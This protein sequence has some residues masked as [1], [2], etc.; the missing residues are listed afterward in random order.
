MSSMFQNASIGNALAFNQDIGD[1]DV[2]K[3]TN[4]SDMFHRVTLSIANYDALLAGWSKLTL[5]SG[6]PF[7]AG[8]SKYCNQLA[9]NVLTDSPNNWRI[10]DSNRATNCPLA[11]E[12]VIPDQSYNVNTIVSEI[13]PPAFG[14]TS[15]RSYALTGDIPPRLA[16]INPTSTVRTLAGTP[17]MTAA[18][19]TL[20]YTVTDSATPSATATLTFTVT[21]NKGEQTG[22]SFANTEV[23]KIIGDDPRS[24]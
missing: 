20:T 3:V 23:I 9:K 1:W 19:V 21:I 18:A 8:D 10:L 6:V 22:F 13:L 2:S 15:P 11:F 5:Q 17:T 24:L 16:F 7:D 4:M 12:R 14:G